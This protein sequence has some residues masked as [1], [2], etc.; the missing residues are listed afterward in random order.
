MEISQLMGDGSFNVISFHAEV[1]TGPKPP[2]SYKNNDFLGSAEAR[3]IRIM[4]E[5]QQPGH[6]LEKEGVE[7]IVMFFGSAR[8]KSKEEYDAALVEAQA[9]VDQD[10]DNAE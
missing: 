9:K 1:P 6:Q 10:P 4:C 5:L 3:M 2:K 8:A 7:N